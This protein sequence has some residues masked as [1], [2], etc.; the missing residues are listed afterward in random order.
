MRAQAMRRSRLADYVYVHG[1]RKVDEDFKYSPRPAKKKVAP[2]SAP[3]IEESE[4]D[5]FVTPQITLPH[6]PRDAVFADFDATVT[7]ARR[8]S[9]ATFQPHEL[10]PV[11]LGLGIV[12]PGIDPSLQFMSTPVVDFGSFGP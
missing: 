9:A 3:S 7:N 8:T 4:F 12:V 5:V 10:P 11:P 1:K 6:F 2:K